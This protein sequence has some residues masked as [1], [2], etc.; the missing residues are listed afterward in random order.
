MCFFISDNKKYCN[1]KIARKDIPVIKMMK[2]TEHAFSAPFRPNFKYFDDRTKKTTVQFYSYL[3]INSSGN[4]HEGLHS[5]AL[6]MTNRRQYRYYTEAYI[7]K[8]AKY[9]YNPSDKEYVST[10]LVI[11]TDKNKRKRGL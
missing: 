8:G 6:N 5:Y 9:Y 3:G 10:S 7:P 2:R 4:I 1:E 11:Y